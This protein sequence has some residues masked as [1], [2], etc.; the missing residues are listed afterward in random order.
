MPVAAAAR[1][2]TFTVFDNSYARELEG[3]DE[4]TVAA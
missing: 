4:R 2:D 3:F 1:T